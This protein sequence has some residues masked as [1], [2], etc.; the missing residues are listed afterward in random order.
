MLLIFDIIE[1][2]ENGGVLAPYIYE[3]NQN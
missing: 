3:K 2:C 1:L